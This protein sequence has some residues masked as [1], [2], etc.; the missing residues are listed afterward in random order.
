MKWN[1][2]KRMIMLI[3][4]ALL[5]LSLLPAA[6]FAAD[7][8]SQVEVRLKAGSKTVKIDGKAS[9]VEAPYVSAGTTMVPLKVI[10]NAFG[11]GLKLE[12]GNVLTLTYNDRKVILTFG[13]KT[14]KINGAA[15]TVAVAPIVVKGSTMV[16][17]RVIVEA[18]GAK[19][20]VDSA[21]KETVIIGVRAQ[22]SGQGGTSIDS[23][24]GKTKVGDSYYGWTLNYPAGLVQVIQSDNGDF[25]KWADTADTSKVAAQVN[26]IIEN[27]GDDKLTSEEQRDVLYAYYDE[28]EITVDKRTITVNGHTFEKQI[29]YTKDTKMYYEYRGIQNGDHYYIVIA[30]LKGTDKSVL[31]SYQALLNSFT[32][33]YSETDKTIKNITKVK[34]GYITFNDKDYGLTVKLPAD[35]YSDSVESTPTY[36][37][38]TDVLAYSFSSIVAGDTLE[39]WATRREARIRE[40][41]ISENLRNFATT[42]QKIKDGQAI[43]LSYEYTY[44][45][46]TWFTYHEVMFISGSYRYSIDYG[47]PSSSATKSNAVFKQALASLDVDTAF[48]EKSFGQVEDEFDLMDRSIR[49][50]KRST[51]NGYSIEVPSYWQGLQNNF[52]KDEVVYTYGSG[53][54][55]IFESEASAADLT[56]SMRE[57][58]SEPDQVAEGYTIKDSSTI[59]IN[60]KTARK[61]VLYTSKP[62]DDLPN[63][64]TLI[65]FDTSGGSVVFIFSLYDVHATSSNTKIINDTIQ[66]IRFN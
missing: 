41:I 49:V 6:A 42:T 51:T 13:S 60:G 27:V 10:T 46:N 28:D 12:N 25:V 40:D 56:A 63:T 30:G 57:F 4:P 17:L 29:T 37:N 64:Q 7:E 31:N 9:T 54:M 45:G 39:N 62:E 3:L 8:S 22:T 24:Y 35:W 38:G 59:T 26:V 15:K 33:S 58:V 43:I 2:M 14:V 48:V 61:I 53:E 55:A 32:P 44:G 16:P 5:V 47:Y 19:I 34:D 1:V 21:T 36:V 11:A 18:F 20:S 52:N 23:D 65:A 50:T 66:S